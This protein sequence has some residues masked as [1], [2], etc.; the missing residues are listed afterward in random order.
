VYHLKELTNMAR[1]KVG[2]RDALNLIQAV[3]PGKSVLTMPETERLIR[4][5]RRTLLKDSAFPVV[6]VGNKYI[7]LVTEL[8]RYMCA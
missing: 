3:Y 7:I 5:D 4:C 1:E 6:K 8:A 2:Y